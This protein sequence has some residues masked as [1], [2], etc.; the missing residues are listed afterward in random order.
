MAT[1]TK[2]GAGFIHTSKKGTKSIHLV[3]DKE[4]QRQLLNH[5]FE[6]GVYIFKSDKPGKDGNPWYSVM[7]SMP[8]DYQYQQAT[9]EVL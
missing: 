9:S 8:D 6:K 1:F 5:D 4:A 2:I 3:L 7:V